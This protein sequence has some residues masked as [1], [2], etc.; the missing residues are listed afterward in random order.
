MAE[1]QHISLLNFLRWKPSTN[2]EPEIAPDTN[3]HE[4]ESPIRSVPTRL[5]MSLPED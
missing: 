3:G 4:V 1:T 5:R 2:T